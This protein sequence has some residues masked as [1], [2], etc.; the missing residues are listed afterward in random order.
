MGFAFVHGHATVHTDQK[1]RPIPW[2]LRCWWL[3]RRHLMW[4]L[5]TEHIAL[6]LSYHSSCPLWAFLCSYFSWTLLPLICYFQNVSGFEAICR[7]QIE[8]LVDVRKPLTCGRMAVP[9]LKLRLMEMSVSPLDLRV[10]R[11]C[12]L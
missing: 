3:T 7:E 5:G 8:S 1:K 12:L 6:F 2:N 4:V 10:L 9:S 11:K